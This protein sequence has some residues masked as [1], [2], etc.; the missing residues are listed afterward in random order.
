M[1]ELYNRSTSTCSQKVR[2]SLAEKNLDYV[3]RQV[4]NMVNENLSPEYLKLNPNGVVP[5]LVH[6][7]NVILDS[8]VICEYL[9]EVFPQVSLTPEGPVSRAKMRAWM[10]FMEE[11]PTA[12]IRV[13][14]FHM[15]IAQR[16]AGMD[17]KTFI[18]EQANIRPL[19]KHLYRRMGVKGFSN[20][21]VA[22][23][24]EQLD[25]TLSRMQAALANGPWL[26]GGQFTLADVIVIPTIDR[27]NDLG[28]AD[29]W[30]KKYPLI[31]PWYRRFQARPSFKKAFG[32]G[33]RLSE[34]Q[35]YRIKLLAIPLP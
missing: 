15:A 28:L 26:M 18:T 22:T 30:K 21:D 6:Y 2:I 9:D 27:M 31:E 25:L 24:L 20:E 29:M 14:S 23:S 12:A 17:E 11:V 3:D 1:L 4:N 7:G 10:R 35:Q 34:S 8:S 33:S 19:R 32:P 13:P 5:T 16:F